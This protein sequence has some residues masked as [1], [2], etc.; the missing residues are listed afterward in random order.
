MRDLLKYITKNNQHMS[1]IIKTILIIF[2]CFNHFLVSAQSNLISVNEKPYN[3]GE[4]LFYRIK[5]GPIHGGDG[6]LMLQQ[7]KYDNRNVF[8]AVAEGKTIGITNKI[9]NVLDIYHSYFDIQSTLPYKTIRDIT[10]GNYKRYQ[11]A[12][13]DHESGTAYSERLDSVIQIPEGIMDMVSVLYY[14][15]GLDFRYIKPGDMLKTMTLFDDELFPFDLRYRGKEIIKTKF[16][17]IQC[18]R[19]DPIVETGRMFKSED[20]MTIWLSDDK[21]RIPVKV[22]FDLILISLKIELEQ[23]SNL[24]YPLMFIRN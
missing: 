23:Y 4:E 19:F 9:Y 16:G 12:Y 6:S 3:P 10:E 13:F 7:V 15:R 20:D 8:Y 14:L 24:K 22:R 5:V 2:I 1:T 21:N 11:E 17:K 18:H